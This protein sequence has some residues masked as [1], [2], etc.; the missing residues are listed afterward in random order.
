MRTGPILFLTTLVLVVFVSSFVI[1][2]PNGESSQ[3]PFHLK[4][5]D[6]GREILNV[7]LEYDLSGTFNITSENLAELNSGKEHVERYING[8]KNEITELGDDISGIDDRA[9]GIASNVK[10]Y[11]GRM[12]NM[13]EQ[14][15][16]EAKIASADTLDKYQSG[17]VDV[18]VT[19]YE[20]NV[21]IQKDIF[22][23][24][25]ELYSDKDDPNSFGV[26]PI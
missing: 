26:L 22:T 5:F 17:K 3:K 25:K 19:K 9:Y 24:S 13:I 1:A 20:N 11:Q 8:F 4:L 14:V 15:G 10:A 21:P 18:A 2:S 16:K 6:M 12:D 23:H 7:A